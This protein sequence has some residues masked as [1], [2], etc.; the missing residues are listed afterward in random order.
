MD[1]CKQ[2]CICDDFVTIY[3]I[4]GDKLVRGDSFSLKLHTRDIEGPV[5]SEKYL[6]RQGFSLAK[7]VKIFCTQIKVG[8]RYYLL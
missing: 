8:L 1:Y 4:I 2:N 3:E 6:Q 5:H 7:L